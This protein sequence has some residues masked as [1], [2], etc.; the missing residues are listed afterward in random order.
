MRLLPR[1]LDAFDLIPPSLCCACGVARRSRSRRREEEAAAATIFIGWL[2]SSSS[3]FLSFPFLGASPRETHL[4]PSLPPLSGWS[5][6]PGSNPFSARFNLL[7][8]AP[9]L[10]Y[11]S[12][13]RRFASLLL[14]SS[15]RAAVLDPLQSCRVPVGAAAPGP[16]K[17]CCL[18][19]PWRRAGGC[20][21]AAAAAR[22]APGLRF[23]RRGAL[24]EPGVP[25]RPRSRCAA[26]I[27][28]L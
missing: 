19:G 28:R 8:L 22:S 23:D 26:P 16:A 15:R 17:G 11:S 13:P 10:P 1:K 4:A 20:V 5:P 12:S 3:P 6:L 21:P 27:P 7:L 18:R 14:L 9:P 25:I 2:D 24:L